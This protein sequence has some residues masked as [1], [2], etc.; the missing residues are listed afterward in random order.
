MMRYFDV[1]GVRGSVLGFGCGSV[2]GRVGRVQSLTAMGAAWGA[3]ITLFDVARSYGYGEAEGLVGE[4]LQARRAEAVIV[5]KFG[6]VPTSSRTTA[7][8][9]RLKPLVRKGLHVVP[10]RDAWF[11]GQRLETVHPDNSR[12]PRCGHRWSRA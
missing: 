4:F 3:G 7:L 9:A 8:K 10:R 2:M 6:I 12:R 5:T 11:N 1:E